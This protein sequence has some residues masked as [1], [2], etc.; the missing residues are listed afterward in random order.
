MNREG[1]G[2]E[3]SHD[4]GSLGP[5]TP[6]QPAGGVTG[7][8]VRKFVRDVLPEVLFVGVWCDR[9]RSQWCTVVCFRS[10]GVAQVNQF[11]TQAPEAKGETGMERETNVMGNWEPTKD[12]TMG[13]WVAHRLPRI[14]MSDPASH[15]PE[16]QLADHANRLHL[17]QQGGGGIG[18]GAGR[19]QLRRVGA[20]RAAP[21]LGFYS[22]G[23]GGHPQGTV[24]RPSRGN[25]GCVPR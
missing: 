15:E 3:R 13:Y 24:P 18:I 10:V 8:L 14:S 23:T 19:G 17:P 4:G 7:D 16:L 20:P 22:E 21:Q 11:Q 6:V 9:N 25:A 12:K 1:W 2:A 5:P